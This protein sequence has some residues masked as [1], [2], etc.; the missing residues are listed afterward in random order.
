MTR[1]HRFDQDGA[2]QAALIC[3]RATKAGPITIEATYWDTVEQAGQAE[4]ELAPCSDLCVNV[5]TVVSV[6]LGAPARR[7][8]RPTCEGVKTSARSNSTSG[9]P[10]SRTRT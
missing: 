2:A 6:S 1:L 5:H 4:R 7:G 10:T 3:H 9:A 8:G